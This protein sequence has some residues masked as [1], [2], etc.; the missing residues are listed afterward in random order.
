MASLM[1]VRADRLKEAPLTFQMYVEEYFQRQEVLGLDVWVAERHC[2]HPSNQ[3]N[4]FTK[5]SGLAPS[6]CVELMHYAKEWEG[7]PSVHDWTYSKEGRESGIFHEFYI[8]ERSR[9]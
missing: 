6:H 4:W 8:M 5:G 9:V 2:Y 1:V 3:N 7:E